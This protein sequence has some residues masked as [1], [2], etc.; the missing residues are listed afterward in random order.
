MQD[1]NVIVFVRHRGEDRPIGRLRIVDDG[2][3]SRSEFAYG[4]SWLED[5]AAFAIDPVQ[6]PLR[7][8]LF[9]TDPDYP[10]FNGL[11]DAAPDAW[12]RKIIDAAAMQK[13]GAPAIEAEYLLA[14]Q[15]G[16]RAGALMFGLTPESP[17]KTIDLELP[18]CTGSTDN[19]ASLLDAA[20]MLHAGEEIP[21]R[22]MTYLA[23]GAELGGARP[24]ATMRYQ[25][26]TCLVKFG[27]ST[28]ARNMARIEAGCLDLVEL[29]GL[30]VPE[31]WVVDVCGHDALVLER[32]DRDQGTGERRHMI[33]STTLMGGHELDR[34][35]HGYSDIMK[36]MRMFGSRGDMPNLA[37]EVF[38]RMVVNVCIGNTDDHYRNHAF[39]IDDEGRYKMSP[40]YDVT[41][42]SQMSPNRST[43]LHL[44][45]A[46][47]GRDATLEA[48]ITAGPDFGLDPARAREIATE[49]ATVIGANWE[50]VMTA[51]GVSD[52]D[53]AAI[54]QSFS[55]SIKPKTVE[56][57]CEC[58]FS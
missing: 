38:R 36:A 57:T 25:D 53:I 16:S 30:K 58:G 31:R 35:A 15:A 27:M 51:R 22:F 9:K 3:Y 13:R 47:S 56:A 24:K 46:G 21:A 6:L 32:F 19:L 11:R 42:T 45:A 39:L 17:G 44:G 29:A 48:A 14:S 1:F 20:E 8:G 4:K 55:E 37:E 26:R 49:V 18:I 7:S 41:P 34:G 2:R 28:D 43:F 5:P 40:V 50:R 33:S 52:N 23:P 54:R 12:G 10:L